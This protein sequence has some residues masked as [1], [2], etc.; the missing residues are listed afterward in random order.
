MSDTRKHLVVIDGLSFF[1]RAYHA[2]RPLSRSDGLPTNAL[3]GFCQM[4]I[5]VVKDL[6]PDACAVALDPKTK[7]FR[8]DI[9]PEYK[10]N[11]SE[12]DEEMKQQIPYFEPLI[13]AFGIPGIRVE[14][15]EADDIIATM[16]QVYPSKGYKMTIVSSDKDLMQLINTHVSMLDTMKNKHIQH[17]EVVEK[18]G[19]EPK[20][21]IDVQALTGDAS[22]NIPGV[23]SVGPKTA[24]Q[25]MEQF[26]TLENLYHN[27][28]QVKRDKLRDKLIKNKEKAFLSKQLVTLKTNVKLGVTEQ[29]LSFHPD[30]TCAQKFLQ[31]MEFNSLASRLLTDAKINGQHTQKISAKITPVK[32]TTKSYEC[33]TTSKTLQ[34]WIQKLKTCKQ[35]ALDTE[36][37]SLDVMRADLVGVSLCIKEGEAC[38]IP[39]SHKK[40]NDD[41]FVENTKQIEQLP[42]TEVVKALKPILANKNIIKVGQNIK[43]DMSILY[44]EGLKIKGFDDT[45]LMSFVL[46]AGRH[47]HNMDA[48][49]KKHLNIQPISYK[50]VAGVGKNQVTFDYVPLD[51]ATDYAAEDADITKCL[52]TLL[53]NRLN[54]RGMEKVKTLYTTIEKP[55]VPVLANM[56]KR[57]VLVDRSQLS[58]LSQEFEK[59]IK[60]HE[61]KIF[62]LSGERFNVASPKQMAEM[63]FD[64]MKLTTKKKGR[65]TNVEVLELLAADGHKIATEI[66]SFR[67]LSKLKSTYTDALLQQINPQ[68]GRVHTSYNQ[69]GAA[70]G[71]FSSSDPNLQNIPI[72]T[73]NGRKI[74]HAFIAKPG[75]VL[76]AA[77]YSQIE[78]RLLAHFSQSPALLAAFREG[79]DI[80]I[81]TAHQ[82]FHVPHANVTTDQRRVA[83][84]INFGIVYGMGAVSLAKQT[85]LT[86]Q[87]ATNHIA[88]YFERY[89][90]VKE[91]MEANKQ[92]AKEKGYVETL[93]G[94]RI[95]L[96]D[97]DSNHGGF[98]SQAERA[99]INA[100]LQ[101]SNADIIKKVM[102]EIEN[103]LAAKGLKTQMLMQVHDELVFEVPE[104]EIK[105]A[106]QII[107]DLM[108]STVA[109]SVPLKVGI[110]TGKNWEEAH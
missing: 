83:K 55:L 109:L 16:A 27:L 93:M 95:H 42:K 15:V 59:Q 97:I 10:A 23:P 65:S 31:N 71:R 67:Q 48:L 5:K 21:V 103:T 90:G 58:K 7:N 17:N 92:L 40:Q 52:Y 104:T 12:I 54:E 98:R 91:Y 101:G 36:T 25:L 94:R 26:G 47:Q 76:L 63:L 79:Q 87:E 105:K 68:T 81:H 99:A 41:L 106:S 22:D 78:L 4:L 45:M 70:T 9:Y 20:G 56:E 84:M 8:Y 44:K 46:D 110:G 88:Q 66:L 57:G 85:G 86:R 18:F 29:A 100:P 28:D 107:R 11:R 108:E 77:D 32:M 74:R 61:A 14:G 89:A 33:V 24:A 30:L 51:K 3:Y 49:A 96:P 1:F 38:Y 69:A 53:N 62:E 19:V 72:R 6:Q 60:T 75:C 35:F 102:P 13:D 43:Y 37:T 73:E 2:V 82:I 80:H 39:V 64:K 50:E 34:K